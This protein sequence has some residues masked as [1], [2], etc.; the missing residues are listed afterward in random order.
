[1]FENILCWCQ[2]LFFLKMYLYG[3]KKT[4]HFLKEAYKLI[5]LNFRTFF[6]SFSFEFLNIFLLIM[7]LVLQESLSQALKQGT[8]SHEKRRVQ[9]SLVQ[10]SISK[11][12]IHFMQLMCWNWVNIFIHCLKR[13]RWPDMWSEQCMS[14]SLGFFLIQLSDNTFWHYFSRTIFWQ[15]FYLEE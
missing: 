13:Q 4:K 14:F 6:F 5:S 10:S 9:V 15:A 3:K 8:D 1:M 2:K 7:T 11:G 12:L